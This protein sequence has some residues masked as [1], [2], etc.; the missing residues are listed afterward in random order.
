MESRGT[1]NNAAVTSAMRTMALASTVF[2]LTLASRADWPLELLRRLP[3]ARFGEA[4]MVHLGAV[5]AL[6]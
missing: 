2:D 1:N 3:L 6:G 5:E 4:R